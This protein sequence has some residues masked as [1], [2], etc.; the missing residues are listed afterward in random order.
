MTTSDK[1]FLTAAIYLAQVVPK[2]A[3]SAL[4]FVACALGFL[5]LYLEWKHRK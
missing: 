5:Y 2:D 4:G 3:A 1:M